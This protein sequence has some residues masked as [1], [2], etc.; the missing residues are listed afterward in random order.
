MIENLFL[1]GLYLGE[2]LVRI[3]KEWRF[4][5]RILNPQILLHIPNEGEEHWKDGFKSA[6]VAVMQQLQTD[7]Y[8]PLLTTVCHSVFPPIL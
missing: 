1:P 3:D 4:Q 7:V 2:V 6:T 8:L 5:E